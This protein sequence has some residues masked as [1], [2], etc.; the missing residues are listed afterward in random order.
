MALV[1][2]PTVQENPD[3]AQQAGA[4]DLEVPPERIE[5]VVLGE[6]FSSDAGAWLA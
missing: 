4:V 6:F 1:H 2:L 5:Q 3:Q